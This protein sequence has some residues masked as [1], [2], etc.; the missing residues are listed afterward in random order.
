MSDGSSA[1]TLQDAHR[2]YRDELLGAGLLISMGVDGLYGR[3]GTFERIVEGINIAFS[4]VGDPDG[5]EVMR[6]PPG[7]GKWQLEQSGYLK[8][9]PQLVGTIHS[10][11][12]DDRDHRAMLETLVNGGDWTAGQKTPV[13]APA[14]CRASIAIAARGP[15]AAG[16][17]LVDCYTYCFRHEP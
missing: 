14:A 11:A 9:S 17:A 15:M 1:T 7:I 6:F 8:S 4:R 3:S 10:F 16:G 12:G 13:L 5:P 2:E